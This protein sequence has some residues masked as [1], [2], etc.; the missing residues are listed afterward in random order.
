MNAYEREQLR[1]VTAQLNESLT[2]VDFSTTFSVVFFRRLAVRLKETLGLSYPNAIK[3]ASKAKCD[4]QLLIETDEDR[5]VLYE[6]V[7]LYI[8]SITSIADEICDDD[9]V[10]VDVLEN[11]VSQS[12][13][14][15]S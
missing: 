15:F 5:D 12:H 4:V 10:M 8:H 2:G 1:D 7:E 13:V 6:M 14:T 3:V 9:S 11:I